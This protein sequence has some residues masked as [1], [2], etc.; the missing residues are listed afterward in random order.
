MDY[1]G[2]SPNC[3]PRPTQN[4]VNYMDTKQNVELLFRPS[5]HRLLE[6]RLRLI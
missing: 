5:E 3:L 6:L 2:P 4:F 1:W